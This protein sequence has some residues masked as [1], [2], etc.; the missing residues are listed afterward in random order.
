[1]KIL[2]TLLL[3]LLVLGGCDSFKKKGTWSC[4][5]EEIDYRLNRASA[6]LVTFNLDTEI[7]HWQNG[8]TWAYEK[9]TKE[10]ISEIKQEARKK[11]ENQEDI[12]SSYDKLIVKE[13]ND[14]YI[15]VEIKRDAKKLVL[16]RIKPESNEAKTWIYDRQFECSL[17]LG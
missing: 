9:L 16:E 3:T 1:M 13:I 12:I 7:Y 5:S 14:V 2:T 10:K 17:N 4:Y 6:A 11:L 15:E 8:I